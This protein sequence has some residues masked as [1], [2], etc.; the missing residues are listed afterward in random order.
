MN[1]EEH[2][3]EIDGALYNL[4]CCPVHGARIVRVN[5]SPENKPEINEKGKTGNETFVFVKCLFFGTG[6]HQKIVKLF[7]GLF[8]VF[9][10]N[11]QIFFFI[12]TLNDKKNNIFTVTRSLT[13]KNRGKEN[14]F[15]KI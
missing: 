4:H 14:C 5:F 10:D 3:V 15:S 7:L 8:C 6:K 13:Q 2:T 1:D 11:L 9:N 12:S